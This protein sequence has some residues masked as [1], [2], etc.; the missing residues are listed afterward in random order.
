MYLMKESKKVKTKGGFEGILVNNQLIRFSFR[1]DR[2]IEDNETFQEY[3][4][5]QA[6]NR[7]AK[8]NVM[9]KQIKTNNDESPRS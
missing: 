2:I 3:K 1:K 4:V 5:R 7:K 9:L 6:F 8:K